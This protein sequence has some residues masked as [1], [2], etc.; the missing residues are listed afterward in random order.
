MSRTYSLTPA[1]VAAHGGGPVVC[2][3]ASA[4]GVAYALHD[5]RP[6]PECNERL[7]RAA[8]TSTRAAVIGASGILDNAPTLDVG[9]A[10]TRVDIR[11]PIEQRAGYHECGGWADGHDAIAER[12]CA[13][14]A[15]GDVLLVIDSP[16]GA[17]AGLVEAVRR[18][19]ACK[20]EFARRVTVYADEMIGSAAYWWAA[21]VG[22]EIY[23]PESGIVGSV[24]ARSSHVSEAAHLASEGVA[25]TYFAWPGEGKVAFAPELP[26]SDIGRARGERDVAIAGEAFAEAVATSRGLTRDDIVALDADAL[27]GP[28][29]VAAGLVD[30][31][32]SF[33]EVLAMALDYAGASSLRDA[34]NGCDDDAAPTSD[35]MGARARGVNM[36]EIRSESGEGTEPSPACAKCGSANELNAKYCDQC[37]E[38][39]AAKPIAAEEE[40]APPTEEPEAPEGE[41]AAE[42]PADPEKPSPPMP[43]K[44]KAAPP[45]MGPK[46]SASIASL[47]GLHASASAPAIKSAILPLVALAQHAVKLTGV[48]DASEAVGALSALAADAAEVGALRTK[49]ATA[50]SQANARE[51]LDLLKQLAASGAHPRGELLEDVVEGDRVVGVRPARLWGPGPEGR[52]LANLR[53]YVRTK[54]ASMT[55]TASDVAPTAAAKPSPYQPDATRVSAVNV[56]DRDREIAQSGGYDPAAVAASRAALFPNNGAQRQGV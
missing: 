36:S 10:L 7:T 4:M 22:D 41:A 27:Y 33:D 54:L 49:L 18:V 48:R 25:V 26:L 44:P 13:A 16:G 40:P 42:E 30:G 43:A 52:T 5:E 56:T 28:L 14:L 46:A 47:L 8:L 38:S 50:Q 6:G 53:G 15:D 34:H 37:G 35:R 24:G 20:A 12:L 31:V 3:A 2:L 32:A 39:M 9:P 45:A 55:S 19:V 51:R 21:V 1:M 29:A 11:G 23:S 17:H